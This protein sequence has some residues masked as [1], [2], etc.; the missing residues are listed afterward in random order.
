MEQ[1]QGVW[2][3]TVL[4]TQFF[5]KPKTATNRTDKKYTCTHTRTHTHGSGSGSGRNKTVDLESLIIIG[6]TYIVY[7]P[8]MVFYVY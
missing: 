1:E 6:N 8:D 2:E 4:F 5:Y 3:F 7:M